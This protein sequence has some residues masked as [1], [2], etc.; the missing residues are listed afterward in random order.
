MALTIREVS[1]RLFHSLAL[2]ALFVG[3]ATTGHSLAQSSNRQSPK[4][5]EERYET[6]TVYAPYVVR[7]QVV[8][9]M[10]SK[11]SS[12]GLQLVSISRAVSFAD[13]DLSDPDQVKQLEGRV[14]M[15]AQDAC[16]EI[17]KK[18]PRT[19]YRPVPENQDCIGNA[20]KAA[21][22]AVKALE[23]AAAKY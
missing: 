2:S 4:F 23:V 8:N 18:F 20:K 11:A 22:V 7:R 21:M 6:L 13:L 19:R 10:M 17:D 14:G 3:A 9:P 12:T 1:V 15:A 16:A 5:E